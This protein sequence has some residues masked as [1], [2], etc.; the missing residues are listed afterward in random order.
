MIDF[1]ACFPGDVLRDGDVFRECAVAID[2][3]YLYVAANVGLTGTALVAQSTGDVGFG[4]DE[5]AG[6]EGC[7]FAADGD[8]FASEFMTKDTR[9][10]HAALRPRIPLVDV[11]VCTTDGGCFHLYEYI[12]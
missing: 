8:D 6:D 3:E 4:G 2:T 5:V 1:F 9:N 11:Q 7:D 12:T 10:G